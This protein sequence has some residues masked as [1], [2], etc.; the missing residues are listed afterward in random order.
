MIK[1]YLLSGVAFAPENEGGAKEQT[2]SEKNAAERETIA[3][4]NN[5]KKEEVEAKGDD[6]DKSDNVDEDKKDDDEQDDKEGEKEE[7]EEGEKVEAKEDDPEKLK[8]TITRLQKRLDKETGS[9]KDLKRELETAQKALE[10]TGEERLTKADVEK[11]AKRIA[12]AEL[13]KRDFE[14]A[15]NRLDKE[16]KKLDKEF[17][18]KID[19]MA[20]DIGPIPGMM[21]GILDDLDN[22][23]AVLSY[24]ANNVD[25]AEEI[26]PLS[27]AKMALKLSKISDK[28]IEAAKPK[29]QISKTP[30]P[31]DPVGGGVKI[32]TALSDKDDMDTW[33]RKRQVQ[34][35]EARRAGKYNLR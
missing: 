8:R 10:A 20:E 22:G 12:D 9:K 18:K 17:N 28:I 4:T 19:A 6:D 29:K 23:G 25:E 24:L 14:N 21:I 31:N 13:I 3:V 26:Y 11:E 1:K 2:Q 33:V 5:D 15:C 27:P 34:I 16:G 32:V 35:D 30:P 7:D